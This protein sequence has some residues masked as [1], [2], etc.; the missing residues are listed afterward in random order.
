MALISDLILPWW[1]TSPPCHQLV[2]WNFECGF[3][4]LS[5]NFE[6]GLFCSRTNDNDLRTTQMFKTIRLNQNFLGKNPQKT[7]WLFLRS[8]F[9][10][11]FQFRLW[12]FVSFRTGQSSEFEKVYPHFTIFL[13]FFLILT[14]CSYLSPSKPTEYWK[15]SDSIR[16]YSQIFSIFLLFFKHVPGKENFLF[17]LFYFFFIFFY[18]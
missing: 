7:W 2:G 14:G 18:L 5:W 16:F 9:D 4:P 3:L 17:T 8:Q 1:L 10:S 6:Y 13:W 12:F 11:I 15:R